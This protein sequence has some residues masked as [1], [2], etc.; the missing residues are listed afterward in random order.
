MKENAWYAIYSEEK[1]TQFVFFLLL[2]QKYKNSDF[3][4]NDLLKKPFST[5]DFTHTYTL[6][7]PST[8]HKLLNYFYVIYL[9]A[10][11]K[12]IIHNFLSLEKKEFSCDSLF[13][14]VNRGE[15]FV[16]RK[17]TYQVIQQ[18]TQNKVGE[19][20]INCILKLLLFVFS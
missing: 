8:K 9:Y 5:C 6:Q 16:L 7:A 20:Y 1:K 2:L 15:M 11:S 17:Q 12:K 4:N 14:W 19:I 10:I 18:D 13:H 3:N